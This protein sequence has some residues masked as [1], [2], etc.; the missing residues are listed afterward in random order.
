MATGISTAAEAV[1]LE[2]APFFST[3]CETSR[4]HLWER[5]DPDWHQEATLTGQRFSRVPLSELGGIGCVYLAFSGPIERLFLQGC[6]QVEIGLCRP[7]SSGPCNRC[8]PRPRLPLG[9]AAT[10]FW[11]GVQDF[12]TAL[13]VAGPGSIGRW[14]GCRPSTRAELLRSRADRKSDQPMA[15]PR[16]G[17]DTS[18]GFDAS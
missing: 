9:W 8:E 18:P 15:R 11:T 1:P 13:P 17:M 2:S 14:L 3:L 12:Q 5:G 7:D 16:P 6:L 4:R 10:F